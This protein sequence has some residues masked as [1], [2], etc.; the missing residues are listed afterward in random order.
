MIPQ[1]IIAAVVNTSNYHFKPGAPYLRNV[2]IRIEDDRIEL[3][4]PRSIVALPRKDWQLELDPAIPNRV[5]LRH[6][7]T[8]TPYFIRV[9]PWLT[10]R[11]IAPFMPYAVTRRKALPAPPPGT[12]F[13][14]IKPISFN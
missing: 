10:R 6:I 2:H 13:I 8:N 1:R 11:I 7:P 14:L 3:R 12:D 4:V 9:N 5:T